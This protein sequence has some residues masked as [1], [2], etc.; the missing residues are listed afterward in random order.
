[1][2]CWECNS[3][4]PRVNKKFYDPRRARPI[5]RRLVS[6]RFLSKEIIGLD[7]PTDRVKRLSR[8]LG[9]FVPPPLPPLPP[10]I[11]I[12]R[13]V[14]NL[15]SFLE[16]RHVPTRRNWSKLEQRWQTFGHRRFFL[17]R[18]FV[19]D[20]F[21]WNSAE[22]RWIFLQK[23]VFLRNF[24][25]LWGSLRNTLYFRE[26]HF[27]EFIVHLDPISKFHKNC[28]S[29]VV[30]WICLILCVRYYCWLFCHFKLAMSVCY[31]L[32]ILSQSIV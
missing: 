17:N 13:R 15:T 29:H 8:K 25:M 20:S 4:F 18:G 3:L 32:R 19:T 5:G 7:A 27:F 26:S 12:P 28:T 9:H 22:W 11:N 24:I 21:G 31:H 6:S 23:N 16:R 1:M 14:E 2:N 10:R 30:K